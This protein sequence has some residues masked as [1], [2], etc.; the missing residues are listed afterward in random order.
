MYENDRIL[1]VDDERRLVALDLASGFSSLLSDRGRGS[2][3]DF[4]VI[5]NL[6]LDADNERVFSIRLGQQSSARRGPGQRRSQHRPL[7]RWNCRH[8]AD[9]GYSGWRSMPTASA[10]CVTTSGNRVVVA[11]DLLTGARSVLSGAAVGSASVSNIRS[12]WRTTR[13]PNP[14]APRLLVSDA[15]FN[16]QAIIAIDLASGARLGPLGP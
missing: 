9:L 7:G 3:P 5:E 2:G 13:R 15:G 1:V 11:I 12:M 6:A 14:A 4:G 8:R 10:H 16:Q